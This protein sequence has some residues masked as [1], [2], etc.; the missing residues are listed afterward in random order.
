M[1]LE[2][3]R[4]LLEQARRYTPSEREPSIFAIAG[5]GYYENPTTDLL[6]F[7]LDPGKP[8]GLGDC[9]LSALLECLPNTDKLASSLRQ[10]PQREVATNNGNRI[11]LVLP[12]DGWDLVLENKIFHGQVNPFSDYEKY[13]ER[14]IS[15]GERRLLYAVLS[16]SGKSTRSA[17]HGVSYS[18]LIGAIRR[19]LGQRLISQ[20][21][22]KWQVFAREFLLHVE[23][24]TV[25]QTM[26]AN[27]VNFVFRNF[28]QIN[29]LSKLKDQVVDALD[30]KV[31]ERLTTEV[32]GY[33]PYTRRHN[34]KNGPALRY[35]SESWQT[36]SDVVL[37]LSGAREVMRPSIR[38]YLC[39]VTPELAERG[40]E[41]FSGLP[42]EVWSEGKND[43]IL[44]LN[45]TLDEYNE[46]IVLDMV[47]EKMRLLMEFECEV[48]PRL[49]TGN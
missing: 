24:I 31:L 45:W 15:N 41:L 2:N 25:E 46:Q 3:L 1:Q 32:P 26:D 18:R 49:A 48:R 37:Y 28:H 9:F 35:A 13:A 38:V 39:D 4:T 43:S 12:G 10:S 29:K 20:P 34:W 40:K 36:W 33:Q 23:N 19:Q 42:A 21:L 22:D 44:G 8:H 7:F 17:W 47:T 6:A 14:N 5:R 30:R 16:P 27:S 11:D